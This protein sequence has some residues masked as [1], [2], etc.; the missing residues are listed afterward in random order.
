MICA[1]KCIGKSARIVPVKTQVTVCSEQDW[2][3]W[4][5]QYKSQN[6]IYII[7]I[8]SISSKSCFRKTAFWHG[9]VWLHSIMK[10]YKIQENDRNCVKAKGEVKNKPIW[11]QINRRKHGKNG[12]K[13]KIKL[14]TVLFVSEEVKQKIQTILYK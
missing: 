4:I 13:N 6:T 12:N 14:G 7:L 8:V 10:K 9:I 5:L 11:K 2:R 3:K 1:L